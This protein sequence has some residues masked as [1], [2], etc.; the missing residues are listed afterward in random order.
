MRLSNL[1]FILPDDDDME[2]GQSIDYSSPA[3][4]GPEVPMT[5]RPMSLPLSPAAPDFEQ[6][7]VYTRP[8][9]SGLEVP[10]TARPHAMPPSPTASTFSTAT[11][12]TGTTLAPTLSSVSTLFGT[13]HLEK[14]LSPTAPVTIKAA[15]GKTIIMFRATRDIPLNDARQKLRDKFRLQ[16]KIVLSRDFVLALAMQESN[17]SRFS[18]LS[19]KSEP[20]LRIINTMEEW[21]WVMGHIDHS[22]I[23]IHI[24]DDDASTTAA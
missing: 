14:K 22:K 1:D 2:H 18:V 24:L 5:A 20:E 9:F 8:T 7:I 19:I 17:R 10:M 11:D 15:L 21:R 16:E 23:T 4:D 6:S 13:I 3:H 12:L